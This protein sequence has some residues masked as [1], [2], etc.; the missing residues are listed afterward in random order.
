MVAARSSSVMTSV[1]CEVP[2]LAVFGVCN[3]RIRLTV[4]FG[5]FKMLSLLIVTSN[6]WV[7]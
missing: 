7:F 6:V 2:I 1:A 4:S 3:W 5:S